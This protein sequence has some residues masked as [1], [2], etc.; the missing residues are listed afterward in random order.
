MALTLT[1]IGQ[2]LGDYALPIGLLI[3]FSWLL[4]T[5][6][7]GTPQ[8]ISLLERLLAEEHEGRLKAEARTAEAIDV[9]KGHTELL[10]E[11]ERDILR[12]QR[13]SNAP[14]GG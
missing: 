1:E 7:L 5:G 8:E 14:Q 4:V 12:Q 11:I 2:F 3:L 9:M 6:R 10:R 13:G